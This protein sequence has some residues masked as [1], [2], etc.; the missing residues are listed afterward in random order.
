M[1]VLLLLKE[2]EL[3]GYQIT[4][5]LNERSRG[6]FPIQ[7]GSLY[8]VLYRLVKENLISSRELPCNGRTRI[9]YHLE[10]Q[11]E[12][13]LCKI[14]GEYEELTQGIQNVLKS[15]GAKGEA[16]DE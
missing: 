3:Y 10:P 7:E 15:S 8:P 12:E 2:S 9:Y 16:K 1:L 5:L 13:W 14:R 11:G 4:Q 6:L